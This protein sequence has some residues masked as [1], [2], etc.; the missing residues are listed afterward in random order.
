ML[1]VRL[2]YAIAIEE[3]HHVCNG[4]VPQAFL[5]GTQDTPL[6]VWA[7]KSE[8]SFPGEIYQCLLPLYGFRSSAA[9]WFRE[10][11][12]F[13]ESLGFIMDPNAVC[14]FRKFL[15]S[16]RTSFVQMVLV[17]DDYALSG[18]E[19]AAT[20]YH[21][22]MVQKFNATTESGQMF[23]GYDIEYNLTEKFVKISFKSYITRMLERFANVDLSKGAPMRELIGCLIWCTQNLHGPEMIK[24]KSHGPRLNDFTTTDYDDAIVTMHS[25]AK[26]ADIGIVYRHGGA[27]KVFVPPSSRPGKIVNVSS[28]ERAPHSGHYE[29]V[30]EF[31]ERDLYTGDD[32][33]H[34]FGSCPVNTRY[35][36]TQYVDS[37][38]AVDPEMRSITGAVTLLCG[39]PM[40]WEIIKEGLV[41]D[42]TTN[43][44]TLSY[45]SGIK[46]IKTIELRLRF[47][48]IQAPKPYRMCTDSTGG[49]L[50]ACNPNKMGRVRHLNIK[51]HLVKCY[52]QIGDVE[53]VYCVT[54]AQLADELTKECDSGQRR[55]LGLRFYNDCIFP[56]GRFYKTACFEQ[57]CVVQILHSDK[58]HSFDSIVQSETAPRPSASWTLKQLATNQTMPIEDPRWCSTTATHY[59]S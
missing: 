28:P 14:H 44:E 12:S 2:F 20:H 33:P 56:D 49:K 45:S 58:D 1:S 15:N 29:M 30:D 22:C 41:V 43:S 34:E 25:V 9:Y 52:I 39:G 8:R 35:S 51:H 7:P 38:F 53:L 27:A 36:I 21:S 11:R 10:V 18:P 32:E 55:N 57:D 46:G 17:V 16:D 31:E 48:Y 59:E 24:V 37:S 40:L 13:L 6:F 42:S 19:E 23:V 54:E 26:R 47:F 3:L 5:Q 4:D 50:L